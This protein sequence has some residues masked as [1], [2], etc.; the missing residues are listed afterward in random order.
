MASGHYNA[1]RPVPPGESQM[2]RL[3][4]ACMAVLVVG[5]SAVAADKETIELAGLKGT[6]PAGWKTE[7]P[8]NQMR[9][10]QYKLEKEKGDS[11]DAELAVFV[12]PGGGGVEANLKRQEA[13][14]K[15]A[16][17]VK[18]EDAIKVSETKVGDHK[19]TY[20]DIKGTFLFKS[21][22]FDPN[23]KVTEKKDFR[24][25]YVIFEDDDK[26]VV[27][28]VLVGPDK[29]IEKHKKDFEGFIKSFKK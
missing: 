14:F 20:Q 19:A 13:R 24:Q 29:T 16:D 5:F 18:K 11:E 1:H 17:G 4:F 27:S 22:P 26:K 2:K 15:L 23:S 9:L 25:L 6:I 8:S 12:L 10:A 3:L 7:K 28:V 21:A